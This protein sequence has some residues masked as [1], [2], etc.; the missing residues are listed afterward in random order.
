LLATAIRPGNPAF[1]LNGSRFVV[2]CYIKLHFEE[3]GREGASPFFW[4][5][6]STTDQEILLGERYWNRGRSKEDTLSH[7]RNHDAVLEVLEE[8]VGGCR[9]GVLSSCGFVGATR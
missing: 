3:P 4:R 1:K 5:E 9:S 7:R 2:I 8:G 6:D